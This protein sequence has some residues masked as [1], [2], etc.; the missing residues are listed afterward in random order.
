MAFALVL[1]GF[2][3]TQTVTMHGFVGIIDIICTESVWLKIVQIKEDLDLVYY[4]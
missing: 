1:I 2:V 3:K 4:V